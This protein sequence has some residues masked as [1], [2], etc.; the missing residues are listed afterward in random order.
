MYRRVFARATVDALPGGV[1]LVNVWGLPPHE[2]EREYQIEAASEDK[3]ANRGIEMFTEEME[4]KDN[5]EDTG[6][7]DPA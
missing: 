7:K 2:Y 4:R 6:T 5:A 1:Y 3:A